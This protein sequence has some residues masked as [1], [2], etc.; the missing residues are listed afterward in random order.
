MT[1]DQ[2]HQHCWGAYQKS[3]LSNPTLSLL[4]QNCHFKKIQMYVT[5]WE[6]LLL[7]TLMVL[8]QVKGPVRTHRS[9]QGYLGHTECS[10][11][12]HMFPV[13]QGSEGGGISMW[14]GFTTER[15]CSVARVREAPNNRCP[16]NLFL[17]F[18]PMLT[19]ML[20]LAVHQLFHVGL[21]HLILSVCVH[22]RAR[23]RVLLLASPH[24]AICLLDLDI[25]DLLFFHSMVLLPHL[26]NI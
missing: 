1:L 14:I 9:G 7:R 10:S 15:R 26:K 5:A 12:G 23:F 17:P 6:A 25:R 4:D 19:L 2:Q 8:I 20:G 3:R 18:I 22:V 21:F 11:L 16:I 24:N 13:S